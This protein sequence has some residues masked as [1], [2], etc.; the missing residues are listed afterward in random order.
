MT[1]PGVFAYGFAAVAFLGFAA[2]LALGWRGGLKASLLVAAVL[3]S[4]AWAAAAAAFA[5]AGL[6]EAWA[7]HGLLD[8]VRAGAWLLF[9]AVLLQGARFGAK[10]APP[11]P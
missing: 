1:Q 10:A 2:H 7:I 5:H 8:A 3:A 4:A 6:A 11:S 9:L